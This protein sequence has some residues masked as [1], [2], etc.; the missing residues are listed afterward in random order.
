M[1]LLPI[2]L[3]LLLAAMPMLFDVGDDRSD[4]EPEP[5][6]EPEPEPEPNLG[7]L[8][9]TEDDDFL[10]AGPGTTTIQGLG[11]DDTI[12][13]D[14][15]FLDIFIDAG[16]GDDIVTTGAGRQSLAAMAMTP[17]RRWPFRPLTAGPGMT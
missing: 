2:G 5:R 7:L 8:F 16:V 13:S 9:G 17:S 12:T 1:E 14:A 15:D 3:M 4:D 6:P 11:G 10:T